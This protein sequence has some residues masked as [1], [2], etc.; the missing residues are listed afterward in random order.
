MKQTTVLHN[1]F[2]KCD[3]T[4]SREDLGKKMHLS[5]NI[6]PGD[7]CNSDTSNIKSDAKKDI[8]IGSQ[9]VNFKD[10]Q[11][12]NIPFQGSINGKSKQ[13][14]SLNIDPFNDNVKSDI[15]RSSVSQVTF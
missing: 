9:G 4:N 8:F 13:K 10:L 3:I 1:K 15:Q 12:E 2:Y 6:F 7:M 5:D 11:M 14:N